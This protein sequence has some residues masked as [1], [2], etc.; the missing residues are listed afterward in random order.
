MCAAQTGSIQRLPVSPDSVPRSSARTLAQRK[1]S[2]AVSDAPP[3]PYR[4]EGVDRRH[5]PL[6]SHLKQ[7]RVLRPGLSFH[8]GGEIEREDFIGCAVDDDHLRIVMVLEGAVDVAYGSARIQLAAKG[9][10]A[11]RLD[12]G[13]ADTAMIAMSEPEEFR[14]VIRRGDFARRVSIGLDRHWIEQSLYGDGR[15][16]A[17]ESGRFLRRHLATGC[18]QASSHARALAEQMLHPPPL[19]PTLVGLYLESRVIELVVE[20]LAL[21]GA[22]GSVPQACR[23]LRPAAF[24]RMCDLKLF[25]ERHATAELGIEGIARHA[26]LS[27]TT[28]QRQFRQAH[29]V[30]VSGFLQ[31]VRLQQART[32]L[33]NE[34]ASVAR[35]ALVAGYSDPASFATAFKRCYGLS[36][37]HVRRKV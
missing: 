16:C 18:W 29:G 23:A 26:G 21:H 22:A 15:V 7:H 33:E 19:P 36:P 8:F 13:M 4:L 35:A 14:R 3:E 27:V 1:A 12:R 17:A 6:D 34:G 31:Q 11:M 20:A 37:R 25:L 28:L 2:A 5:R 24:R 9:A 10:R 30:T 32:V